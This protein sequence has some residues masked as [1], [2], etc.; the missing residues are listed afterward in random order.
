MSTNRKHHFE[1]FPVFLLEQYFIKTIH[2]LSLEYI[3][4]DI[5][6]CGLIQTYQRFGETSPIVLRQIS[7]GSR[8]FIQSKYRYSHIFTFS[9]RDQV[10]HPYNTV[11]NIAL[12]AATW[13]NKDINVLHYY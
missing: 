12:M 5:T 13:Q 4:C 10:S 6:T 8:P 9:V 7:Q 2:N 1:I 3:L 11:D